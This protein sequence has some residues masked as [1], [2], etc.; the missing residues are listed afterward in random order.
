MRPPT[1]V[2]RCVGGVARSGRWYAGGSGSAPIL[3]DRIESHG[4]PVDSIDP[5][6]SARVHFSGA[7]VAGLAGALTVVE[8]DRIAG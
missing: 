6:H 7:G 1:C 3:L 8:V 5:P 4:R 2:I